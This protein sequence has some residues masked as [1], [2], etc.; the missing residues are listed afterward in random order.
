MPEPINPQDHSI[1]GG[2]LLNVAMGYN[3]G[4]VSPHDHAL[5]E[6]IHQTFERDAAAD[7]RFEKA[8]AEWADGEPVGTTGF[9]RRVD[10]DPMTKPERHNFKSV[11]DPATEIDRQAR[12][13]VDGEY[14]ARAEAKG[15]NNA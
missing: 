2:S 8:Q 15:A 3:G 14:R 13:I 12:L 9:Y 11:P 10:G 7:A 5:A 1:K 4:F 6:A